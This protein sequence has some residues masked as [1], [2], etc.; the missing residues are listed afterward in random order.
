[1]NIKQAISYAARKHD[2]QKRKV[3]DVPYISHPFQ[4]GMLLLQHGHKEEVVIAGLLH[5]VVEDT[6][7]TLDEIEAMFGKEVA[8]LVSYASEPDKSLSWEERKKHTIE[9]IKTASVG[10]KLVVCADKIDNLSSLLQNEKELGE[11]MW[12]SFKRDK[13]AQQWYYSNIYRSLTFGL[14]ENEHPKLFDDFKKMLD[15]FV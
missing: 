15:I 14:K 13:S 3:D 12:D 9:T 6:D 1:M 2:G 11:S 4:V 8:S 7:G 10:A 5:D